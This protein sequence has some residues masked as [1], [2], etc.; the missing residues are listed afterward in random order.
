MKNGSV[1]FAKRRGDALALESVVMFAQTTLIAL[2]FSIPRRIHLVI[3]N[4]VGRC[5]LLRHARSYR[6]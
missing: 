6:Q 2:H 5:I 1:R 3:T 4:R